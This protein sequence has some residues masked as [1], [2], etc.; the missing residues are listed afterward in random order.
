MKRGTLLALGGLSDGPL[1]TFRYSCTCEGP[2][3]LRYY[4][5]RLRAW[6][7]SVA[8]EHIE[9]TYRRYTGDATTIGKG[10]IFVYDQ[11]Q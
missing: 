8:D 10:E 5:R 1:P 9:G 2:V 3:F 7:L 6:G 4:L 11:R